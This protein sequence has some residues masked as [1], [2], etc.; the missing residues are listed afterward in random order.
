MTSVMD[1]VRVPAAE[2]MDTEIFLK[3][4]NLRHR[5]SLGGLTY[6]GRQTPYLEKCWRSFHEHLHRWRTDLDHE[7]AS[8]Q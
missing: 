1:K 6:L 4:M 3:H 7:H 2:N 8:V 5:E